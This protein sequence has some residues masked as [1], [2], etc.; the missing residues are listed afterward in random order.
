MTNFAE[1]EGYAIVNCTNCPNVF[2][3]DPNWTHYRCRECKY[4]PRSRE[5]CRLS[6]TDSYVGFCAAIACARTVDVKF[7]PTRRAT[8][9]CSSACVRKQLGCLNSKLETLPR[10]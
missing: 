8:P 6:S 10:W 5:V 2:L 7:T 9:R 3:A 1:A 4:V